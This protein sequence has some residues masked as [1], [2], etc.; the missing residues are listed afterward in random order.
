[1]RLGYVRGEPLVQQI[2]LIE[3]SQVNE[4]FIDKQFDAQQLLQEESEFSELLA[5]SEPGDVMVVAD[6]DIISRDYGQLLQVI[7]ELSARDLQLDVLSLPE[8]QLDEWVSFLSWIRKNER[9]THPKLVKIR[10]EKERNKKSYT[11][12]S[13][14]YQ[15]RKLY[16]EIIKSLFRHHSIKRISKEKRVPIET[17]FRIKKEVQRIKLATILV[18]C[19]LLAIASV[20]LTQQYFDN[21]L[22]QIGIC[23]IVTL[24]IVWN[25]LSDTSE[26]G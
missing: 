13:S 14:D 26:V 2:D 7:E 11:L 15:S 3:D 21:I 22:I 8:L 18:M 12:F 23:V 6:L 4:L 1:M 24:V 17:V 20:K 25:V 19:F 9:I 16:V 5:F 10:R